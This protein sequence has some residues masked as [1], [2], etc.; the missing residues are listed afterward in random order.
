MS[1]Q[2]VFASNEHANADA[3]FPT[4]SSLTISKLPHL[5]TWDTI[6]MIFEI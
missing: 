4:L 5:L 1:M 2:K 6:L 3:Y